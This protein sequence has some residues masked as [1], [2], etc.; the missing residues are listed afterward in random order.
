MSSQRD[1]VATMMTSDSS[2]SST[3]P[4]SST[5]R[6]PS[7]VQSFTPPSFLFE[8]VLPRHQP[9]SGDYAHATIL[10]PSGARIAD[11][12]AEA[13]AK[14]AKAAALS[15]QMRMQ[16]MISKGKQ[17]IRQGMK[18]EE[19]KDEAEEADGMQSSE[20]EKSP[21][22]PQRRNNSR[23]PT[24]ATFGIA[25]AA[26]AVSL[27]QTLVNTVAPSEAPYRAFSEAPRYHAIIHPPTQPRD[28]LIQRLAEQSDRH[29]GSRTS[30]RSTAAAAAASISPRHS[31]PSDPLLASL[32]LRTP[33]WSMSGNG[34]VSSAANA[35]HASI[36]NG[37]HH[38]RIS[39]QEQKSSTEHEAESGTESS[40]SPLF[41]S[42]SITRDLPL[43]PRP[44]T[45]NDARGRREVM[46]MLQAYRDR[47]RGAALL[48][49]TEAQSR[50]QQERQAEAKWEKEMAEYE[51]VDMEIMQRENERRASM[52]NQTQQSQ[53]RNGFS[54]TRLNLQSAPTQPL[55]SM[56]AR[57]FPR[58]APAHG[59]P[60]TARSS[61]AS[62][63]FASSPASPRASSR[64]D[65]AMSHLG[66]S[67]AASTGFASSLSHRVFETDEV[68]D[69]GNG[70]GVMSSAQRFHRV[71]PPAF[72]NCPPRIEREWS[73]KSRM[74]RER[75]RAGAANGSMTARSSSSMS[76]RRS[77]YD[78]MD[79]S[80]TARS[81]SS[82]HLSTPLS[83]PSATDLDQ[84]LI[85][86]QIRD[87]ELR[88][89]ACARAGRKSAEANAYFCMGVLH[90]NARH[91]LKAVECYKKFKDILCRGSDRNDALLNH[92]DGKQDGPQHASLAELDSAPSPSLRTVE[93]SF[94]AAL[95]Y[96]CM[97]ISYMHAGPSY[98]IASLRCHALH[99]SVADTPGQFIAH[100]N[101]GLVYQRMAEE[102]EEEERRRGEETQIGSAGPSRREPSHSHSSASSTVSA[103]VRVHTERAAQHHQAALRCALAMSSMAGQS[104]SISNLGRTALQ[105]GDLKTARTCM[106]RFIQLAQNLDDK[107][108][109]CEASM[110]L[111]AIAA[112][113]HQYDQA[114][115][116]YQQ[117]WQLAYLMH[118]KATADA[119]KVQMGIARANANYA[120][121]MRRMASSLVNTNGD[122]GDPLLH[123]QMGMRT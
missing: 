26:A 12:Q 48:A 41:S 23:T 44:R 103:S 77:R 66:L 21:S 25:N 92:Q 36:A 43:T 60:L 37:K 88:A 20:D 39:E 62:A 9:W 74:A 122:G 102:A 8:S 59:M 40:T 45:T 32:P 50:A 80:A 56:S 75:I 16:I 109:Q 91:Y 49:R 114:I 97:G 33:S 64:S 71:L 81:S 24:A 55:A 85:H 98:Y 93:E 121:H 63:A 30:R 1:K 57:P 108:G 38:T 96:N 89:L 113:L 14:R 10:T 19:R 47:P 79:G 29:G 7:N 100:S 31:H 42:S 90:D 120:T 51:E 82:S 17:R 65:T 101:S 118:D 6:V 106:E 22:A 4:V 68:D 54:I 86:A 53:T 119:A 78:D 67:L 110:T 72:I 112:R 95:A 105:H 99:Q 2:D 70:K 18:E 116:H 107:P 69:S 104:I 5:R 28:Q 94:A 15:R 84:S 3:F 52:N 115:H 35:S 117:A 73:E 76:G 83:L 27:S 61:M 46:A 11:K 123:F 34:R 111:G 58:L 87:Y 13:R